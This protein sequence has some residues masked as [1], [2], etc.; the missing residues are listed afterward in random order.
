MQNG[1]IDDFDFDNENNLEPLPCSFSYVKLCLLLPALTGLLHGFLWPAYTLYF[2]SMHW[3]LALAG[4]A[5]STGFGCRFFLQQCQLRTGYWLIVPLSA[6]HL[7]VAILALIYQMYWWAVFAQIV[8]WLGIDP[9]C[10]IEGIAFD[11]F[12][13]SELQAR[14]ATSTVLSV[15]TIAFAFSC[16]FGGIL[17]DSAGWAGMAVYHISLQGLVLLL[18]ACEPACRHSFVAVFFKPEMEPDELAK[19]GQAQTVGTPPV[20]HVVPA[21]VAELP[22]AVEE[23]KEEPNRR[24]LTLISLD[25]DS[26]PCAQIVPVKPSRLSVITGGTGVTGN[27]LQTLKT[28]GTA[29]NTAGRLHLV[30][31]RDARRGG[32]ESVL[33]LGTKSTNRSKATVDMATQGRLKRARL[34]ARSVTSGT[35]WGTAVSRQ[36][37]FSRFSSPQISVLPEAGRHFQNHFAASQALL[38]QI[39]GARGRESV[40]REELE[41]IDEAGAVVEAEIQHIGASIPKDFGL[42]ALCIQLNS[43][44]NTAAYI[45]VYASFAIYF[46][47]VHHRADAALAGMTQTAGDVVG[48]LAMQAIPLLFRQSANPDDLGCFRRFWYYLLSKPYTLSL[49]LFTWILFNLGMMTSSLPVA[50]AAQVL[51]GTTFVCSCKWSTD[52]SLLYSMGDSR[53]F[54]S[55]QERCR[56]ADAIGGC[57]AG[58]LATWLFSLDPAAPFLFGAAMACVVFHIY[59]VAFC[60]RAGFGDDLETAEERRAEHLGLRRERSAWKSSDRKVLQ[61]LPDSELT[62]DGAMP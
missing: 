7:I 48:A 34:T 51:V 14:Q 54:L 61:G 25:S 17:F 1:N 42:P 50:I 11:S 5:I 19:G 53:V 30:R 44:C 58:I 36:S 49:T 4:L 46:N 41:L 55:L 47:Q 26:S 28:T 32:R 40:Q 38:P 15:F 12:C 62:P 6:I 20:V 35:S 31:R 13:D 18:L 43:F 16:T 9:T 8:V 22:C 52:M 45:L 29:W 24:T 27:T 57:M 33:S 37:N 60:L 39:I 23:V 10:A 2:D 59:T 56:N 3:P 21:P